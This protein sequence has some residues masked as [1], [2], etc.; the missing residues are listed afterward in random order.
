MMGT[1]T[2]PSYAM[3][4]EEFHLLEALRMKVLSQCPSLLAVE[5]LIMIWWTNCIPAQVSISYVLTTS[6]KIIC[7]FPI[8]FQEYIAVPVKDSDSLSVFNS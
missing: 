7:R 5:P 6:I 1:G 8:T 3:P 4:R 2:T